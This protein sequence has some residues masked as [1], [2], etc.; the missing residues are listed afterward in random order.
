MSP[1]SSQDDT[2]TESLPSASSVSSAPSTS[3]ENSSAAGITE[4]TER[5]TAAT[6]SSGI[7]SAKSRKRK[8]K[9]EAT[10]Q[11][12]TEK[13]S[14]ALN[15]TDDTELQLKLS[16]SPWPPFYQ[17]PVQPS[18]YNPRKLPPQPT[19]YNFTQLPTFGMGSPQPPPCN[20][21]TN[22]PLSFLQVSAQPQGPAQQPFS[23][24]SGHPPFYRP[25]DDNDDDDDDD[26]DD[27]K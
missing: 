14:S 8:T 19:F 3:R 2:S 25:P 12:F 9:M 5:S 4:T 22:Q 15:N 11:I 24:A 6:K 18:Q 7:T 26:D 13:I 1:S 21:T 10:L 23:Q 27:D 16:N 20:E 17:A